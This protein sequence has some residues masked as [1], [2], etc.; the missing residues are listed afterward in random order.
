MAFRLSP[1]HFA[2]HINAVKLMQAEDEQRVCEADASAQA[3]A[4]DF[5]QR[6][7]RPWRT[8]LCS[9]RL[10]SEHCQSLQYTQVVIYRICHWLTHK[11]CGVGFEVKLGAQALPHLAVFGS[12]L[13][14]LAFD[15]SK[16]KH[17]T[18]QSISCMW[19]V[20]HSHFYMHQA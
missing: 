15:C 19:Q 10:S 7:G 1:C 6:R 9:L 2:P 17:F 3:T 13:T 12:V 8:L 16:N 14:E 5:S 20:G 4:G 18:A 11:L